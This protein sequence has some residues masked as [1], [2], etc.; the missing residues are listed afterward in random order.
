MSNHPIWITGLGVC[1]SLGKNFADFSANLLAGKNG[2]R[3]VTGFDVS[4]HPCQIGGQVTV[5][6]CPAE[7]DPAVYDRMFPNDRLTADCCISAL[8]DAGLWADRSNLR[9]GFVLGLGRI[10]AALGFRQPTRRGHGLR[11]DR[12][13]A[14]DGG[15]GRRKFATKRTRDVGLGGLRSGNHALAH[16]SAWLK[17]GWVDVCIAGATD[18]GITPYSLAAFGNLRAS[19]RRNDTP[20]TACGR[21]TATA[22][23]WFSAKVEACSYWNEPNPPAAGRASPMPSSPLSA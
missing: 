17:M 9:I 23:E 3:Q 5:P 4:N 19:S 16:A 7:L 11:F 21:S 6:T 10:D 22:M 2:I 12:L 15:N 14:I 1:T 13:P 20:E 18:V 8:K